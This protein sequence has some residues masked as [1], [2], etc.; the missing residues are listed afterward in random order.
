M[1]ELGYEFQEGGPFMYGIAALWCLLVPTALG[2][3]IVGVASTAKNRALPLAAVLVCVGLLPALL[4]T[5]G[6]FLAMRGVDQAL[7]GGGIDPAD[8]ATIRAAGKSEALV[9]IKYGLSGSIFP[10]CAGLALLGFGFAR[11]SAK[12]STG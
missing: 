12:A 10:T 1:S 7:A 4:G 6:Y 3:F 5:A 11:R 9:T 8:V 2:L